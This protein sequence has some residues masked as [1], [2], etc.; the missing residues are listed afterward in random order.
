MPVT[1]LLSRQSKWDG[2]LRTTVSEKSLEFRGSSMGFFLRSRICKD[3]DKKDPNLSELLPGQVAELVDAE[4]RHSS[5]LLVQRCDL[6]EVLP[7]DSEAVE[8]IV[9]A[10]VCLVEAG[11]MTNAK[12]TYPMTNSENCVA[13]SVS[14]G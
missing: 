7:E 2:M 13:S 10:L 5:C 8:N 3:W 14:S 11:R 6:L 9:V 1:A 12:M 4:G